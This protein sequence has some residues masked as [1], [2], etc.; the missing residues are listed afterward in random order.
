MTIGRPLRT[1]SRTD[2]NDR[3]LAADRSAAAN[4][5]RGGERFDHGHDGQMMLLL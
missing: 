3:T 2:L 4:R 5:Q 1:E